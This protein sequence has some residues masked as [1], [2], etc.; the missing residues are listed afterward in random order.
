MRTYEIPTL[1][2]C[3]VS[4]LKHK[5]LREHSTFED[6]LDY[7]VGLTPVFVDENAPT[8]LGDLQAHPEDALYIFGKA[9]YSPFTNMALQGKHAIRIAA[10]KMGM[11]WPHQALAIVMDHRM[12]S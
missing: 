9:T 10:P 1:H 12:R 6:M 8:E 11:L 3:P 4:G 2:M 7:T 5:M